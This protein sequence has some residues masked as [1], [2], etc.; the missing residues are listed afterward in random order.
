MGESRDLSLNSSGSRDLAG[1][2][3][4]FNYPPRLQEAHCL[5]QLSNGGVDA[6]KKAIFYVKTLSDPANQ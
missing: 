4:I 5:F 6:S 1:M 2:P 3:F